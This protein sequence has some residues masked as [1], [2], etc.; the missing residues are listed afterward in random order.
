MLLVRLEGNSSCLKASE[1]IAMYLNK[2]T[3]PTT[4]GELFSFIFESI[5]CK[6]LGD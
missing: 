4:D 5:T 3:L 1:G 6:S 2:Y